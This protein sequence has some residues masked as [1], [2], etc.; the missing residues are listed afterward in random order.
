MN[1]GRASFGAI[2]GIFFLILFGIYK[3]SCNCLGATYTRPKYDNQFLSCLKQEINPHTTIIVFDLHE[4]IFQKLIKSMVFNTIHLLPNGLYWYMFNPFFMK[5]LVELYIQTGI[6][7]CAV[8]EL[9]KEYPDFEE[10]KEHFFVISNLIEPI[11]PMVDVAKKLKKQG[12]KLFIL[13]N[14]GGDTFNK[15]G[16]KFPDI[17][18]IFDG[19]YYPS[20]QNCYSH[21]PQT[22][23]YE[24]FKNYLNSLCINNKQIIFIDD[25]KQNLEA[26]IKMDIAGIHCTSVEQVDKMLGYLGAY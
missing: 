11:W 21:K 23:F 12:Y 9:I 13:S 20:E 17:L 22:K 10:F 2:Y 18:N 3:I 15:L 25:L 26:A 16:D 1:V 14:I 5:R 4:V 7:E 6:I 24:E 8:K 19:A